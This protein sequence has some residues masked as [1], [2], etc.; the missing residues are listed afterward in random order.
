MSATSKKTHAPNIT[1]L[2]PLDVD[3]EKM[4]EMFAD[5]VGSALCGE[6][7]WTYECLPGKG[8]PS[9]PLETILDETLLTEVYFYQEGANDGDDWV[10]LA[11]HISGNYVYF[12]ASCDYSG[13]SCQ[14]GGEIIIDKSIS[15]LW[16]LGI[17]ACIK[18]A[19]IEGIDNK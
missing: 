18:R 2:K 7:H 17:P 19:I 3:M 16:Q 1:V 12:S 11:K 14:G 13:F 15:E 5:P 10:F 4:G 9:I 8:N 6:G